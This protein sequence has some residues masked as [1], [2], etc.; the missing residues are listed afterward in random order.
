MIVLL[1]NEVMF[2]KLICFQSGLFPVN[3]ILP[4]DVHIIYPFKQLIEGF[5]ACQIYVRGDKEE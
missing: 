2:G 4:P 3:H 1:E 5:S